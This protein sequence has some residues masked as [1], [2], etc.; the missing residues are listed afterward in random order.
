MSSQV[1]QVEGQKVEGQSRPTAGPTG[2]RKTQ[3]FYDE[4]GWIEGD[5]KLVDL[6]LFGIKEDGPIRVEIHD[7]VMGRVHDAI[8]QA[9]TSIDLLEC[10][11]GGSPETSLLDLCRSY[12]G[13]D[14]S[15]TG[16]QQAAAKLAE[17]SVPHEFHK[18]DVCNLPFDDEQFD[19][20]Y[21]ARMIYH[22][23]DPEAQAQAV[24]ELLRVTRPG[25]TVVIITANP[26]PLMFPERFV[27]RLIAVTPGVG[28]LANKVRSAP[29]L[30]YN[31]MSLRWFKRQA[32][33]VGTVTLTSNGVPSTNFNQ[34]VS[35]F[36]T[37]G[38]L[39]WR[40]VRWIELHQPRAAVRLGNY[41]QVT[42]KK[43]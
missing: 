31:P 14:F 12:T 18:A 2:S 27:K 42:I 20:V 10:G 32:Q 6:D 28:A 16:L 36:S 37:L 21:S 43:N 15:E 41:T 4:Q 5:G 25:G 1:P 39:R 40:V 9:G 8:A 17:T 22:I 30:P 13:A 38:Q 23:P 19:A 11:C 34:R 29:P 24:S 33:G 3:Q 35:E 7:A 26:W